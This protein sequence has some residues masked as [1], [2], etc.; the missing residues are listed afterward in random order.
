MEI[1]DELLSEIG[2]VQI[3]S[4]RLK[5][6]KSLEDEVKIP[7]QISKDSDIKQNHI[8][9]VLRQLKEHDLV[10]CINPEVKKG[11]L[12]RLTDTGNEIVKNLD[13]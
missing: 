2:Y 12:Y 10:E 9:N 4:Y 1:S 6:M 3:S 11:R 7:S 13:K 8:S 5:V